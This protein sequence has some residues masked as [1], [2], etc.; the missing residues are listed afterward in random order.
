MKQIY[1]S[2]L[3]LLLSIT[4][5]A[6]II[7]F[8]DP[9]FKAKLVAA[10]PSNTTAKDVNYNSITIDTNGDG[11]IEVSE[12]LNVYRLSLSG[13]GGY[14][15]S[16]VGITA[17]QNLGELAVNYHNLTSLDL[18]GMT[19]LKKVECNNNELTMLNVSGLV[20]LEILDCT[21]DQSEVG[22]PNA[23]NHM[24]QIDVSTLTNL[25]ELEAA[26]NS[27]TSIDVS[28]LAHLERLDVSHN[29]LTAV[30]VQ[31]CPA[32]TAIFCE[33]NNL[34]SLDA[35]NLPEL[36]L[37]Y[38]HANELQT[39]NVL[40]SNKIGSLICRFN[41]LTT[42]DLNHLPLL[43]ILELSG[44]TQLT[45]LFIKNGID[46]QAGTFPR[47]EGTPSLRYVCCDESQLATIQGAI[48]SSGNT[49]CTASTFCTFVP[50]GIYYT[51]AGSVKFDANANGCD[52]ADID[53]PK[54]KIKLNSSDYIVPGASGLFNCPLTAGSYTLVPQL[55]NPTYFTISP[56]SVN[57][58]FPTQASPVNQNFCV[59]ANGVHPDLEVGILPV[60]PSRP[61]FSN[62]YRLVYRNKGNQIQSGNV[63]LQFNDAVQ[64]LLSANPPITGSATN[65]L[66]WD[67]TNLQP[68]ESR[69]IILHMRTNAP[70][71]T[72]P[73]IGGSVVT[74][75]AIINPIIG[76]SKSSD[77]TFVLRE[78]VVNSFDP[79]DKTCLEGATVSPAAVGE[80]VHYLIRF[81]NTGSAPAEN[82]VV[83]DMIDNL[84]FDISTLIPFQ[85]S[86]P[87]QTRITRVPTSKSMYKVEFIFEN[88]NL[89][90][91]DAN[92]DGHLSF[93]I[94]TDPNLV[95]GNTFRNSASI[96]FDYNFPIV[97]NT[98]VTTVAVLGKQDFA[99]ESYFR[100]YPN[101]ASDVLKIESK[102][103]I[104]VQSISIYNT[105]GQLVLVVPNAKG[106]KTVDVSGLQTGNYFIKIDSDK[107]TS[108]TKFI[109]K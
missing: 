108:N 58:N 86:H 28:G 35:S 99:F 54:F 56:G 39:I 57:V 73:I 55:E 64:N 59:T 37:I 42:L 100:I 51:V 81:E 90:F 34:S 84:K 78:T 70:T 63:H 48:N 26:G 24:A 71:D 41:L 97:T 16:L 11:E 47:F 36:V 101:P 45:Q 104:E 83:T 68:F 62:Y 94:K 33:Y 10:S 46:E 85:S 95:L 93:K 65:E 29:D 17:F 87:F 19:S 60:L 30:N 5:N 61:G 75:T 4:A 50:G 18:S 109:K 21:G 9:I 89:P 91:D 31:N 3:V 105:L 12:T 27:L 22:A 103:N 92:N 20:N 67:F 1:F 69:E 66:Y 72:P 23:N 38:C 79:N 80:Y 15:T 106:T 98:A 77:N 7:N 96:Y 88:I 107:G 52:V 13:V 8:P 25:K 76:D 74:C 43:S 6:Q 2:A 14:I 44:N 102:Q 49:L 53:F 82:I 32:L 40:N